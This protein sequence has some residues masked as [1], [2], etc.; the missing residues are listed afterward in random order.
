MKL[1]CLPVSLYPDLASGR[2]SP[3]DW[4]RIAAALGLDGADLS[5]AHLAAE[6]AFLDALRHDADD[7]GI[8]LVM[9][10]TYSDF[11]HPDARFRARQVDGIRAWI[12][13]ASRL[14]APFLRVTAGQA[15]PGVAEQDGLAWA[16]EGLT[17]CAEEARRAD[18]RLL[19]ENHTRGAVWT[20]NDFTLPASRFLE[21]IART[22]GSGLEVLFDT[23]NSLVLHDDPLHVLDQVVDRLGAVHVSDIRRAGAFEPTPVGTGAAPITQLLTRVV[24]SGF[25]GWVSIEEASRTGPGAFRAAVDFVDRVWVEAGG[26][27]RFSA[28]VHQR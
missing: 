14:G 8:Q 15:H 25:D 2:L 27:P 4:V 3:G 1:S 6:P 18:V 20:H 21:V 17:A 12:D 28:R 5:V 9:L 26:H 7:A 22:A 23:A 16:T 19:Y 13:A 24:A 11:T 10:A